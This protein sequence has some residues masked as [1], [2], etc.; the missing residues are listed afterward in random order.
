[1]ISVL[2]GSAA[3]W[4]QVHWR[5]PTLTVRRLM[6]AA[7]MLGA[8]LAL[9]PLA[10]VPASAVPAPL[11]VALL[12]LAVAAQ[13][14]NY[15]G[16]H[17]CERAL[18]SAAPLGVAGPGL[19]YLFVERPASSCPGSAACG[20]CAAQKRSVAYEPPCPPRPRARPQT[21]KTWRRG[22]RGWCW[23]LRTL[24][25]RWWELLGT[26]SQALSPPARSATRRS[27]PSPWSCTP[28][29]LRRGGRSRAARSWC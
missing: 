26:S 17:S 16:F 21:C 23:E 13:G 2:A 27:L 25:A 11:A 22:M 8:A 20:R 29:R 14:F 10:A 28:P 6:Q 24:A 9:A 3:D 12:T 4:V 15:A 5:L 1:M 18:L 19:L 7:A